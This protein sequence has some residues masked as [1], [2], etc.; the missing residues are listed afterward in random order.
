MRPS[1]KQNASST[2]VAIF[3]FLR[4]VDRSRY[5]FTHPLFPYVSQEGL[6]QLPHAQGST[7]GAGLEVSNLRQIWVLDMFEVSTFDADLAIVADTWRDHPSARGDVWALGW[8][9]SYGNTITLDFSY[10]S[11]LHITT[12]FKIS[13]ICCSTSTI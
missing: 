4:V 1:K 11:E 9:K 5:L 10:T 3:L 13:L 2:W 12:L 8:C 6:G 7:S